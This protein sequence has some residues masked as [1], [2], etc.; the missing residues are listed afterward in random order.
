MNSSPG[1]NAFGASFSSI[2]PVH[3][4]GG[5]GS[6]RSRA[7]EASVLEYNDVRQDGIPDRILRTD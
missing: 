6:E 3:G 4:S 1:S 5:R 2:Y 7:R